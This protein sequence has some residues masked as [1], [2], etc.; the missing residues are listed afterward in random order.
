[1]SEIQ[2]AETRVIFGREHNSLA[3]NVA[4]ER[5]LRVDDRK[6]ISRVA[7]VSAWQSPL[8]EPSVCASNTLGQ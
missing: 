7:G 4:S 6:K 8:S 1:M 2:T 3:S 5:P